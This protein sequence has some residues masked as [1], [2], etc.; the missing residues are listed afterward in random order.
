M[1]AQPELPPLPPRSQ[2]HRRRSRRGAWLKWALVMLFAASLAYAASFVIRTAANIDETLDEI[3]VA[4]TPEV[5]KE[6]L[7]REKPLAVLLLGVDSR[8]GIG[9]LNTDVIMVAALNPDNRDA[10]VVSIPRDT[11][12]QVPGWRAQKANAFY[13]IAY[14]RD[15]IAGTLAQVR[16]VF[17]AFLD[18][19]IDYAVVVNFDAFVRIVDAVG[20]V[21]VYVD[22][23]MRYHDPTDGTNINLQKGRQVLD[24]KK[25]LDFVRY[26]H[27]NSGETRESNDFE[28]NRRQQ[29][30]LAA[31]AGKLKSAGALLKV[32]EFLDALGDNVRTDLPRRQMDSLIGTYGGLRPDRLVPIMLQGT[33]RSPYVYADEA[34]LNEIRA[35]LREQLGL[36]G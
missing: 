9:G 7:A 18:I 5:P 10:V 20:G 8:P 14:D 1:L 26:R 32:N 25:A 21:E 23:D 13:A 31:L 12:V 28:R 3:S 24:G 30:G 11:Y 35:M 22:Q 29:E 15:D 2:T 16:E 36:G 19:P 6:E 17:G 34:Q 27:S 33:W 4:P